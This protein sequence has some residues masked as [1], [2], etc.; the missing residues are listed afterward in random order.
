MGDAIGGF[1]V[2]RS[3]NTRA[4]ES[5]IQQRR[6]NP[7]EAVAIDHFGIEAHRMEGSP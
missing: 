2:H 3:G 5:I 4:Y 1:A 6:L 7:H